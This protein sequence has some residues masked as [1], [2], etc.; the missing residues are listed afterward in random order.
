MPTDR[1]R[2]KTIKEAV[3]LL[4]QDSDSSAESAGETIRFANL[5]EA[6][7]YDVACCRASGSDEIIFCE[8]VLKACDVCREELHEAD[9]VLRRLGYDEISKMLRRLARSARPKPTIQWPHRIR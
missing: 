8:I 7:A 5:A 1:S 3:A 6:I 2:Q 9:A 4:K